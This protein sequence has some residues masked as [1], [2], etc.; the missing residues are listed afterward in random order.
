MKLYSKISL[1]K[2][3]AMVNVSSEEFLSLLKQYEKR[4]SSE[5]L[6]TPFEQ[7]IISRFLVPTPFLKFEI[8]SDNISISEVKQVKNY[9]EQYQKLNKKMEEL[10]ADVFNLL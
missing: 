2:A 3:S 10:C 9:T 6:N 1:Q 5:L 8:V 4:E 7:T